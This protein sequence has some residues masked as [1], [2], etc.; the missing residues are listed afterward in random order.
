MEKQPPLQYNRGV[1]IVGIIIILLALFFG[2]TERPYG[3]PTQVYVQSAYQILLG[4]LLI[5]PYPK[6]KF[7]LPKIMIVRYILSVLIVLCAGIS[8]GLTY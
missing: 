2:F 7:S 8:I 4:V 1:Q 3:I 6:E 5:L